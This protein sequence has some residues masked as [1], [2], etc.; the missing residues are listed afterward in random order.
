MQLLSPAGTKNSYFA[1]FGWTGQ[2]LTA[3]APD[4]MWTASG[5]TLTPA[6]PVT[7]SWDNGQGQAFA[8]KFAVDEDYLFTAEQSVT[9]NGAAAVGAQSYG[10]VSRV[11][12]QRSASQAPSPDPR[13]MLTAGRCHVGP[14]GT[15]NDA[16]NYDVDYS[17]A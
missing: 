11:Y 4:T 8:I 2:G 10:F 3:P 12:S 17:D 9:N 6:T 14:I 1:G 5:A 13:M 16:A 7:L 15:F